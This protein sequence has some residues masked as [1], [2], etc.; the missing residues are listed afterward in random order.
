MTWRERIAKA[1][2]RGLFTQE[3]KD[4]AASWATCGVGEKNMELPLVVV[5][6]EPGRLQAHPTGWPI[7]SKLHDLGCKFLT[8]VNRN[9]FGRADQLLD[10]IDDAVLELKRSR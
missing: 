1:R 3:D 10:A 9:R 5:Y 4:L 8:E 2:N 7:S 6:I